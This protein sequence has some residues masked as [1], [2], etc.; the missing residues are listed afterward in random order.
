MGDADN[1]LPPSKKR[2]AGRELSRDNPGLDDEEEVPGQE[3]GTFK[4]ASE[5]VLAN[6]RI[7]K[8]RRSQTSSAPS[9]PSAPSSNPFASIRLIPTTDS[10]ATPAATPAA[11]APTP[12]TVN[13]AE[14]AGKTQDVESP[15]SVNKKT[16]K[17][18][19]EEKEGASEV[20]KP[21]PTEAETP[22]V[23]DPEAGKVT[24]K[25][26]E[27]EKE[28][29]KNLSEGNGE[30]NTEAEKDTENEAEK[31]T[32]SKDAA[33]SVNSFQ[34]LSSSQNAFTGLVGTGF[35]SSTFSFGSISKTDPP[36]FPS[37]SF[38]TN[39]NSAL[40]GNP[41]G[42]SLGEKTEGTKIPS[43]QEVHVE[44][45]EE[46]EMAV[47]T[48]DA[49]LF[50]FLDGGWK[51]RGKGELKVNV[52]TTGTKK[53]RLVMRAR[54]NYRL[55]LNASIFPDMKLTNMEKKGITF[56]CLNSTGEGQNGLSTFA[57]KFKDAAIVDEFRSVVT[58]HKGSMVAVPTMKTPENSPKA[59]DE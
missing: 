25:N 39:G 57:L 23:A 38:G 8:V 9:A 37:F 19:D 2:A 49:A 32:E 21:E 6:R 1:T 3:T 51:E 16:E 13:D 18:E 45:G 56:A 24:E 27:A 5:E 26:T 42:A 34:Q 22:K 53:A 47:F 46:N 48:A 43:M 29:E 7:V 30:K 54:G 59:S 50:E 40:F 55:I 36:S 17:A 35:S 44:T 28:T 10:T 11:P 12:A 20:R 52:L 33:T 4:R 41:P 58:E 31:E 15:K 14:E